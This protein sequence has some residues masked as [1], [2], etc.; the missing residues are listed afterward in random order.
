MAV[1]ISC[2]CVSVLGRIMF[3]CYRRTGKICNLNKTRGLTTLMTSNGNVFASVTRSA[4]GVIV[5]IQ[6]GHV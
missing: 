6:A 2:V 3:K 1:R 5:G 4:T